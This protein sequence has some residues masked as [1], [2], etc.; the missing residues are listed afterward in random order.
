MAP[1]LTE[2]DLYGAGVKQKRYYMIYKAVIFDLDGTLLNTLEDIAFAVNRVLAKRGFPIH[3]LDKYRYFVGEGALVLITR[4]LPEEDR[5]KDLI[6]DV[7]KDFREDYY[8]NW[9]IRTRPYEGI[10]ELLDGLT[11]KGIGMAVL[12]NKPHEMAQRC[13]I[14]FF[15]GWDFK[16]V[17]GQRDAVQL[18][19]HPGGAIEIAKGLNISPEA[20]IYVG[21]TAIDMQTARSAGMFPVG[22]LW[23]FRPREELMESGARMVA[24][25]PIDVL[26]IFRV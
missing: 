24:E 18:K 15:S 9:A 19:P 20:F 26:D 14:R 3:D 8:Q 23:G 16:R 13:V 2:D 1:F 22:V 10:P 25:K 11:K 17:L 4:A 7:I 6:Q 5:N 21:D 12:S